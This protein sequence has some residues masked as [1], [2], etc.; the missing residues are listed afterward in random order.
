LHVITYLARGHPQSLMKA[1][2]KYHVMETCF[3]GMTFKNFRE[4]IEWNVILY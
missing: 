4:I 1:H 2:L 3:N